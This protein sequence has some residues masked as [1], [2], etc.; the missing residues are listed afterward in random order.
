MILVDT[1]VLLDI[2]TVDPKWFRWSSAQVAHF[3]DVDELVLSPVIYAELAVKAPSK[4]DL[5]ARLSG[6]GFQSLTKEIAWRAAKA[7]E[8]YRAAGGKRERV[9]GDFWIGAHAE[10]E[11]LA[12]LTRNPRDFARFKVPLM[13]APGQNDAPLEAGR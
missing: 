8:S 2:A 9:L 12:L 10:V 11:H 4:S 1:S 13:I 6:F 7:F 5:E 3:A